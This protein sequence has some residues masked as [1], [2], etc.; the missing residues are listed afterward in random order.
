M[1]VGYGG[2]RIDGDWTWGKTTI[3]INTTVIDFKVDGARVAWEITYYRSD[4]YLEIYKGENE[5]DSISILIT[6]RVSMACGP[7]VFFLGSRV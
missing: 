6:K 7:N 3:Y 1:L 5:L 4:K 2:V